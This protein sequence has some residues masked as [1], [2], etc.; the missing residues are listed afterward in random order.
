MLSDW[1]SAR[2]ASSSWI[3]AMFEEGEKRRKL[4]G[5]DRVFDF[6]LGNPDT[7]P[8]AGVISALK[9]LINSHEP[10]LHKYMNNA[11]YPDVRGKIAAHIHQETD[12]AITEKHIIMTCGAAGGLNVILKTILNPD[13]EVILF[14]PYFPEYLSYIENYGGK[15][16]VSPCSRDTFEPLPEDLEKRITHSTKAILLNS[17]NNPTGVVYSEKTLREVAEVIHRKEKEYNINILVISDEPYTQLVYDGVTVPSVFNTFK[18]SVI[19]TSFSKSLALPGERIGYIA[20]HPDAEDSDLLVDGMILSN[21]ILGFV[22]APSLFQKVIAECLEEKINTELYRE[23]RDFLYNHLIDLGFTC[24]KPKGAFYLFP[25]APIEDDIKFV[26]RALKYNI[27]LV[28]GTGFGCPGHIR[29]SYSVDMS[30]IR[31]SIP[32]FRALAKEFY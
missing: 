7:E 20:I 4:Y 24:I 1:I 6:S 21:R 8:P 19:V 32:A 22:N 10:N 12:I 3:R 30:V 18:N 15:T 11:G 26:N 28:P 14:S 23:R 5:A 13:D 2:M 16:V 29:I 17:P 31:R 27:L 9:D 25:K